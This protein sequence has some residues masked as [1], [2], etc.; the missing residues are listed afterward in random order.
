[1]FNCHNVLCMVFLIKKM[2]YPGSAVYNFRINSCTFYV[3]NFR[4][5]GAHTSEDGYLYQHQRKV[6]FLLCFIRTRWRTGVQCPSHSSSFGSHA[7]YCSISNGSVGQWTASQGRRHTGQPSP[8]YLV[9]NWKHSITLLF[10]FVRFTNAF[11]KDD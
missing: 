7:K 5:N 4:A 8:R 6:G 1:M 10:Y 11:L 9:H 2:N 3:L